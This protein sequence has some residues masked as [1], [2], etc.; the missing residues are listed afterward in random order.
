M[1][2]RLAAVH[3]PATP[4]DDDRPVRLLERT[5][6]ADEHKARMI[7]MVRRAQQAARPDDDLQAEFG[8][9]HVALIAHHN[10]FLRLYRAG[11]H[12]GV[13]ELWLD[14][15]TALESGGFTP[16]DAVGGTVFR[17][18]GWRALDPLEGGDEELLAAV[19]AALQRARTARP[20]K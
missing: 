11:K 9:E 3:T 8:K 14:D 4:A 19:D 16:R 10:Q 17:L 12:A 13:V 20:P 5:P 2:R 6:V 1:G 18:F 7:A 15:W